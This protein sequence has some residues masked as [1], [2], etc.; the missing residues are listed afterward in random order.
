MILSSE[1]IADL[2]SNVSGSDPFVI[3]PRPDI[4]A[5]RASGEAAVELRLGTWFLIPRRTTHAVLRASSATSRDGSLQSVSNASF[6]ETRYVP[7][8]NEFVLHPRSFVL[9]ATLEWVRMTTG[10]AGY[11]T[12][13]SS[14][15]RRGLVIETAPGVHPGF[16]GCLTLELANIGEVPM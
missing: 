4:D 11:V 1:S 10:H 2:L 15:G 6:A 9:A 7:F 12:G 3:A 16:S 14:W 8:G 5:L 13:K